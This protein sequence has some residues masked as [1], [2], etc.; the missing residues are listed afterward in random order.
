M[1]FKL[2]YFCECY[3]VEKFEYQA[4]ATCKGTCCKDCKSG[5]G[6]I[7]KG[8]LE[9]FFKEITEK[10]KDELRRMAKMFKGQ[11]NNLMEMMKRNVNV[12]W[13]GVLEE[14]LK[15]FE[16]NKILETYPDKSKKYLTC[17]KSNEAYTMFSKLFELI[18][19]ANEIIISLTRDNIESNDRNNNLVNSQSLKGVKKI[20]QLMVIKEMAPRNLR[21]ILRMRRIL[22]MRRVLKMKKKFFVN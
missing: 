7:C 14:S 15:I 9:N 13:A 10:D 21:K 20:L 17:I 18:N 5:H 1:S 11:I 16:E 8:K 2:G 19:N 12:K 6:E 3:L 22:K 4:C